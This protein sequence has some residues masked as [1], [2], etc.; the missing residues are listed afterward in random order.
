MSRMQSGRDLD[1]PEPE[2]QP[3][4]AELD[5]L[6]EWAQGLAAMGGALSRLAGAEL[7]LA[8][9]DMRRLALLGLL[10]VPVI[11]FA[12]LGF[13]CLIG[14]WCYLIT[15]SVAAGLASFV[16]L[17]GLSLAL[18]GMMARRY[19]RSIGLPHT[20]AQIRAIMRDFESGAQGE[21]GSQGENPKN[22][23]G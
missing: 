18:M 19:R 13:S 8:L 10:V 14:W 5:A 4:S 23:A 6:L 15:G 20:R 9:G 1:S 3:L 11:C 7:R 16:V 2:K 22:A 17:Q 12:W 21:N